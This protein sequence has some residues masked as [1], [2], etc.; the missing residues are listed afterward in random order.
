M[1]QRVEEVETSTKGGH[2]TPKPKA[3]DAPGAT[4]KMRFCALTNTGDQLRLANASPACTKPDRM[5]GR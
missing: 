2:P 3:R 4:A 5:V 1:Q